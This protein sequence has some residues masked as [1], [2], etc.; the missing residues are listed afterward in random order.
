MLQQ[1]WAIAQSAAIELDIAIVTMWRSTM[2]G[3]LSATI[4]VRSGLSDGTSYP[5]PENRTWREP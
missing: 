2:S 1:K 4:A 5:Y 3:T